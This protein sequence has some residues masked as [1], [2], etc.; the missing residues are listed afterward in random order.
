MRLGSSAGPTRPRWKYAA[1]IRFTNARADASTCSLRLGW[2]WIQRHL[3]RGICSEAVHRTRTPKRFAQGGAR[4]GRLLN[5]SGRIHQRCIARKK[6]AQRTP[7]IFLFSAFFC[8]H[9]SAHSQS[10][11]ARSLRPAR[12][13]LHPPSPAQHQAREAEHQQHR[14]TGLGHGADDD[15]DAIRLEEGEVVGQTCIQSGEDKVL[16]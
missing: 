13:A 9:T 5:D 10:Q 1:Q 8:G 2:G 15:N 11:S 4:L 6:Y 3:A 7:R 16:G 12:A 14:A